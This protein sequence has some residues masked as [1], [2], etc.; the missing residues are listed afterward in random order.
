MNFP[1]VAR[2]SLSWDRSAPIFRP[3]LIPRKAAQTVLLLCLIVFQAQLLAASL[4]GCRHMT[5]LDS[6]GIETGCPLHLAEAVQD[7][8]GVPVATDS[9]AEVFDC[10][11]CALQFAVGVY[12]AFTTAVGLTVPI[13]PGQPEA[14]PQRHFYRFTPESHSRPPIAHLL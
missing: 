14:V 3:M 8:N 13:E 9:S 7:A 6:A 2:A 12:A 5:S 1:P 11:K 4:L 10:P